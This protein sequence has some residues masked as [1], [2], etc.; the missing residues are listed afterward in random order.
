MCSSDLQARLSVTGAV[1][2]TVYVVAVKY[3]SKTV[4]GSTL[5]N[6]TLSG[7]Y[8]FAMKVNST[9]VTSGAATLILKPNNCTVLRTSNQGVN[10]DGAAIL[11]YPNP[12]SGTVRIAYEMT[13]AGT[14]DVNVYSIT[15]Q[16]VMTRQTFHEADGQFKIELP[17]R[18]EALNPGLYL[19]RVIRNGKADDVRV[20]LSY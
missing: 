14:V 4:V 8:N 9:V 15:G 6:T 12:T 19:I 1:A 11:A 10:L 20:L 2:G 5:T 16:L 7:T 17:L 13:E 18:D 3:D